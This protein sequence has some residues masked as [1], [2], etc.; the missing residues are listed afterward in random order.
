MTSEFGGSCGNSA[1][2][3][4]KTLRRRASASV[5]KRSTAGLR[6]ASPLDRRQSRNSPPPGTMLSPG[7]PA[8]APCATA[9]YP[10]S[11]RRFLRKT[12]AKSHLTAQIFYGT[13]GTI[14]LTVAGFRL[15]VAG[16]RLTGPTVNE[17]SEKVAGK[18]TP[19]ND[20]SITV[21]H[22]IY[23]VSQYIPTVGQY[24]RAVGR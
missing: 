3:V 10:A 16:F 5:V 22:D 20:N 12:A 23:L 1:A 4:R 7:N 14:S 19:V 2:K 18:F 8:E 13:T 24:I 6:P 9:L 15:T 17:Q 21:R 11:T